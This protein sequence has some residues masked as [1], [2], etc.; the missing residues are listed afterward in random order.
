MFGVSGT[1][2]VAIAVVALLLVGPDKL[3]DYARRAGELVRGLRARTAELRARGAVEWDG[4]V[5]AGG[6]KDVARELDRDLAGVRE[7]LAEAR[8]EM[9]RLLR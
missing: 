6:L 1:E 9:G 7:D 3:P 4:V 2:L 5:D 8:D